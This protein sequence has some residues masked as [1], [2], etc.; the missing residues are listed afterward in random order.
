MNAVHTRVESSR[1]A[2]AVVASEEAVNKV[3]DVL[4]LKAQIRQ[5]TRQLA[6]REVAVVQKESNPS[7]K[8]LGVMTSGRHSL[9]DYVSYRLNAKRFSCP[10]NIVRKRVLFLQIKVTC[11]MAMCFIEKSDCNVLKLPVF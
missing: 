9:G 5:C 8:R 3:V 1:V 4:Q 10:I 2:V 11:G 6:A 7:S